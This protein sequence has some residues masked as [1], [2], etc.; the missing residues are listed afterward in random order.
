MYGK[1]ILYEYHNSASHSMPDM[2][3][4]S[5]DNLMLPAFDQL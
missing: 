3:N 1:Q 2:M 5:I 4:L